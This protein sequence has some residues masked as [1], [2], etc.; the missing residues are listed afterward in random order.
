V[1]LVRGERPFV[2]F[3]AKRFVFLSGTALATPLFPLYY[4]R[5]IDASD[6]QIGFISTVQT[7][8]LV[9][10]YFFWSRQTRSRGSRFVL[11][12]T[13]LMISLY[14]A[15]VAMTRRVDLLVVYAGLAGIFQ[16]GIDLVFFDELMKTVP[17]KYSATFVALAQSLLYLSSVVAPLVG[18]F[19]ADQIGIGGGLVVSAV[20]RL[21]GFGLFVLNPMAR[22]AEAQPD[23]QARQG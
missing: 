15:V 10:G 23:I 8:I 22:P 14:P 6:A 13:T 21:V 5:V 11:L 3:I 18:A 1:G 4:V 20:L 7:A 9:V 19:L 16:A 12:A 17:M 2:S